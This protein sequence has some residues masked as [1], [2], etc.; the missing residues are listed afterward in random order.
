MHPLS[1]YPTGQDCM[2]TI[3]GRKGSCLIIK[4]IPRGK[5]LKHRIKIVTSSLNTQ[6]KI[7][8]L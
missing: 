8:I 5:L 3:G 1:N 6:T 4:I 2:V 7:L